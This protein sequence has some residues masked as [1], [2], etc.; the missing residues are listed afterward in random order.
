MKLS[1]IFFLSLHV[2]YADIHEHMAFP[3]TLLQQS[4]QKVTGI[5]QKT[6]T[7]DEFVWDFLVPTGI[8]LLIS[9]SS[10]AIVDHYFPQHAQ[11]MPHS[12]LTMATIIG[13]H[14]LLPASEGI[15]LK[16]KLLKGSL[17]A[18]WV[19]TI[20]LIYQRYLPAVKK[21][22]QCPHIVTNTK[23]KPTPP[24][25]VITQHDNTVPAKPLDTDTK[26]M[27]IQATP[28]TPI[29]PTVTQD[30]SS[31]HQLDIMIKNLNQELKQQEQNLRIINGTLATLQELKKQNPCMQNIDCQVAV[32]YV[33]HKINS[34]NIFVDERKTPISEQD[35]SDFL[36]SIIADYAFIN[37]LK[38]QQQA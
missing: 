3:K 29:S 37:F 31:I 35:F 25:I 38:K 16:H 27:H 8:A 20:L 24:L 12:L 21:L 28:T 9:N 32:S 14:A 22:D 7:F 6:Y 34:E 10:Y 33:M 5:K 23:P 18:S 36:G 2:I 1:I 11:K 19:G 15:D 17:M 30:N 13:A 4:L 26:S